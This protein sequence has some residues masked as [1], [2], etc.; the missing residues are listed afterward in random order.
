M[1]DAELNQQHLLIQT[2]TSI[3]IYFLWL[4][5]NTT[6]RVHVLQDSKL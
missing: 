5:D 4:T 2:F 3:N 6:E 1:R